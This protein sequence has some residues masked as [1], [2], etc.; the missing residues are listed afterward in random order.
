MKTKPFIALITLFLLMANC[1]FSQ[2]KLK[3]NQV[4]KLARFFLKKIPLSSSFVLSG[5][6][7][8]YAVLIT[9]NPGGIV[10]SLK[11]SENTPEEFKDNLLKL[12][13][14]DVRWSVFLHG[15]P[16]RKRYDLLLTIYAII[17]A[18]YF[19][20]AA[21]EDGRGP[22][23]YLARIYD[24]NDTKYDLSSAIFVPPIFMSASNK[25]ID[26]SQRLDT[27]DIRKTLLHP[28]ITL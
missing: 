23:S 25:K 27:T 6:S 20:F 2:K 8:I 9:V 17:D 3:D 14:A 19:G 5:K 11:F 1:L 22:D 15:Q 18:D 13:Q 24:F 7:A 26:E 4:E 21:P 12:K 16:P 28:K 10:T